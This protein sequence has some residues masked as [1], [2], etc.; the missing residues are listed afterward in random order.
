[1]TLHGAV[2]VDGHEAA[3]EAMALTAPISFWG[4]VNPKTGEIADVR[5]PQY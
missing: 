2:L 5:H 3:A 4:G 1:M